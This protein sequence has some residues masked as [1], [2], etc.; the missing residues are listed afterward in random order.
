MDKLL[1]LRWIGLIVVLIIMIIAI[2]SLTVFK[3]KIKSAFYIDHME[4]DERINRMNIDK[5]LSKLDIQRGDCIADIGAGSGLFSRKFSSIVTSTGKVYSVDINKVLLIYIDKLN[6]K[7]NI[8]NIKTI[9]ATEDD[10]KIPE[11]VDLIFICDT[12]HYIEKQDAYVKTMSKYL[13]ANGR[14]AVISFYQN[15]PPMS[16][17]FS[18]KEL[19]SWVNNIGLKRINYYDDFIQDEYLAIYKKE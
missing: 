19:T 7:N 8:N 15:W 6:I 18:E 10:P 5:I 9:L 1:M 3:E 14:I 13:K 11:S 4:R 16:N 12:L 2:L 17:E